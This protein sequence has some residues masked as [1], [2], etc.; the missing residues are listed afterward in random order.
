MHNFEDVFCV[1]KEEG[2]IGIKKIIAKIENITEDKISEIPV[3][4]AQEMSC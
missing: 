2:D 4:I 3:Y 1:Y